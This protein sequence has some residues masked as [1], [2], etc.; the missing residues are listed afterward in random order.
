MARKVLR[1]REMPVTSL[2][3]FFAVVFAGYVI[4]LDVRRALTPVEDRT[5]AL[6]HGWATYAL[7]T[8]TAVVLWAVF[9]WFQDRPGAGR[10]EP[11]AAEP[12]A[13]PDR[14]GT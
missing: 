12:G 5:E 8:L 14:R 7:A 2:V 13:A 3:H 1:V 9:Y 10:A 11:N 4:F 6:E